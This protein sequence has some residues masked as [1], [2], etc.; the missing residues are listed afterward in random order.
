MCGFFRRGPPPLRD[1]A[2]ARFRGPLLSGSGRFAQII[3]SGVNPA[4]LVRYAKQFE[5]H[6]DAAERSRQHQVVEVAEV[7]DAESFAREPS[8]PCAERHVELFENH[9]AERRFVE[10]FGQKDRGHGGAVFVRI[11]RADLKTPGL[12][13]APRGFGVALVAVEDGFACLLPS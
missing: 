7:A 2:A 9:G 10:A 4:L 1:D 5:T 8:E 11:E 3:E 13:R 12:Y 6:L